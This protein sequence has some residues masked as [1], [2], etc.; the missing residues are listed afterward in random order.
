MNTALIKERIKVFITFH[1]TQVIAFFG[2]VAA[3]WVAIPDEMKT[4][5]CNDFPLFKKFGFYIALIAFIYSFYRARMNTQAVPRTDILLKVAQ[6]TNPGTASP[7]A[8]PAEKAAVQAAAP[9]PPTS[10][11][12]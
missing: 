2:S 11:G 3:L 1:S 4:D 6:D 12:G 8:T 10:L 9:S 5:I 7:V